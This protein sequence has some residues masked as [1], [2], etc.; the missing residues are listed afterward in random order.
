MKLS[1]CFVF[2]GF[3]V[4]EI[5]VGSWQ[6]ESLKVFQGWKTRATRKSLLLRVDWGSMLWT[7][8]RVEVPVNDPKR[9]L[10]LLAYWTALFT[11]PFHAWRIFCGFFC[12][13][14]STAK[15][16]RKIR[17]HYLFIRLS[18]SRG[19]KALMYSESEKSN[20][21][22]GKSEEENSVIFQQRSKS[23]VNDFKALANCLLYSRVPFSSYHTSILVHFHKINFDSCFLRGGKWMVNFLSLALVART[24]ESQT[25]SRNI[26]FK[27]IAR[28]HKERKVF[29]LERI[30]IS[31]TEKFS[32]TNFRV[33]ASTSVIKLIFPCSIW[34]LPTHL[35][36]REN[37]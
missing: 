8:K 30:L 36:V 25:F 12:F 21:Y 6:W 2:C 9:S 28:L 15:N 5:L 35:S 4:N 33:L 10:S 14:C 24:T 32:P 11:F 1:S 29:L 13:V 19:R 31:T 22:R 18:S 16:E 3:F 23:E 7:S 20:F 37:R 27:I 34:K 17:D 26:L